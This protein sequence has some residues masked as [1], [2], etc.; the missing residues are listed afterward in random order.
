MKEKLPMLGIEADDL[1][2]QHIDRE[3]RRELENIVAAK[4]RNAAD[5]TRGRAGGTRAFI[6]LS[7][8]VDHHGKAIF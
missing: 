4:L 7:P 5:A 3:V 8:S 2:R 6:L 1:A